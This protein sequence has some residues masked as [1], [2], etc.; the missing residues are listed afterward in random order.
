MTA[1]PERFRYIVVEGPIGVGKTTLAHRLAER[2]GAG[3]LLED[4]GA[5]PFL[6]E[7]ADKYH[8]PVEAT[9]GGAATMY[10]EYQGTITKLAA[11]TR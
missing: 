7:F 9:R 6:H 2:A 3:L 4:P 5:N 10:P 8:L 1:L 11:G